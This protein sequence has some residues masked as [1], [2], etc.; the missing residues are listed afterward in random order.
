MRAFFYGFVLLSSPPRI[1]RRLNIPAPHAAEHLW[2]VPTATPRAISALVETQ[3]AAKPD[4][5]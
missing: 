3:L 5:A 1:R 4:R 2:R